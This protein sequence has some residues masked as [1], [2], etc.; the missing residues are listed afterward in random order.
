MAYPMLPGLCSHQHGIPHAPKGCKRSAK[1]A[2][3]FGHKLHLTTHA[4]PL[5]ST[6]PTSCRVAAATN[7]LMLCTSNA[8][9][10]HACARPRTATF[11]TP[12]PSHTRATTSAASSCTPTTPR[13]RAANSTAAA[14]QPSWGS[15]SEWGGLRRA[16]GVGRCTNRQAD[17]KYERVR[18]VAVAAAVQFLSR[19]LP[20]IVH[21]RR[22]GTASVSMSL[23]G[24]SSGRRCGCPHSAPECGSAFSAPV[25]SVAPRCVWSGPLHHGR[26][27]VGAAAHSDGD[28]RGTGCSP[29][30]TPTRFH[31]Q[32]TTASDQCLWH[33]T[34]R[35]THPTPIAPTL[36][37]RRLMT[38]VVPHNLPH[39]SHPTHPHPNP[40]RP[41]ARFASKVPWSVCRKQSP[42]RTLSRGRRAR[43]LAHGRATRAS[44]SSSGRR[45]RRGRRRCRCGHVVCAT[46]LGVR[47]MSR[48]GRAATAP[49]VFSR[50][51][52]VAAHECTAAVA[53]P[54]AVHCTAPPKPLCL[55]W[56]Q[57]SD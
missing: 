50:H 3:G 36:S 11:G 27:V 43:A 57:Y 35:P 5:I 55:G 9:R 48:D 52:V 19:Q 23:S 44:R 13:A 42:R 1:R 37:P 18:S 6:H 7:S 33:P 24:S 17:E 26:L 10:M 16:W 30:R 8:T 34:L 22:L 41:T 32:C 45:W 2:L 29:S 53:H 38:G 14:R 46:N 25:R 15:L 28:A 49:A 21:R 31:Q 39:T 20:L 54:T 47:V 56:R 12:L 40:P 4:R 51:R